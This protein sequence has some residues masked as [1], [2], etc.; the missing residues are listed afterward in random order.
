MITGRCYCGT[1]RIVSRAEPQVV[2]YCHCSDC[3][4]HS[5]APVAA[6]AGFAREDVTFEPDL[7]HSA[8]T[9]PGVARWFCGACGTPLAATYDYLPDQIYIGL[10]LLDH[11]EDLAPQG[12]AHAA[13]TLSWLHIEDELPRDVASA[14]ARLKP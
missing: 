10:G 11:A 8:G 5:G 13:N 9:R 6:F 14:R 12:H 7:K 2:T 4:R 1:S 3:K